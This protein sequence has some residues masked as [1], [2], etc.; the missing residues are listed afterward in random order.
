MKNCV[1]GPV[2]DP[3]DPRWVEPLSEEDKESF[4]EA[5]EERSMEC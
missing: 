2:M 5:E 4:K 1:W 3:E